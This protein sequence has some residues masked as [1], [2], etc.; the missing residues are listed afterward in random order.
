[1][2]SSNIVFSLKLLQLMPNGLG[3]IALALDPLHGKATPHF[4]A[5]GYPRQSPFILGC[6]KLTQTVLNWVDGGRY[7]FIAQLMLGMQ[8][9][10]ACYTHLVVERKGA[11]SCIAPAAFMLTGCAVQILISSTSWAFALAVQCAAHALGYA[12]GYAVTSIGHAPKPA[13]AERGRV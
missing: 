10:G 11:S 6:W 5:N 9:G 8:L 13:A 4:R 2:A 7:M 1:M 12:A 3:G